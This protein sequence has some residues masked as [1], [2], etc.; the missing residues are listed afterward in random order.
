VSPYAQRALLDGV[1]VARGEAR[2]VFNLSPGRPHHIQLEHACCFPWVRDFGA[3]EA[4]PPEIKARLQPR[5]ARLRVEGE[6]SARVYVNDAL[7]GTAGDSQRAPLE[8]AVPPTGA[9]PYEAQAELR[10]EIDGRPPLR[11]PLKLRAGAD[12]T[13]AVPAQGAP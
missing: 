8:V 9:S 13:F 1:E 12:V 3:G 10:V 4:F 5:P 2:V 6:P 11:A 7:A